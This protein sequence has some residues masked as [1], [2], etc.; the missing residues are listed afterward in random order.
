MHNGSMAKRDGEE[1]L[2]S[3]LNKATDPNN[4]DDRW[5]CIQEFYQ[6]VNQETDGPQVATRLLAHKI[7]SPQDN[8]AL[9]A[10][11]ILEACMDN[12][13]RRF[14]VE[15]VKFRFLNELI[16]VLIPKYLGK[17]SS[18]RVKERVT[19]VLYGW[20]LWLK[21]E[22]KI[23]EAYR[24]LKKQGIVK[25]DPTLSD[26]I[27]MPPP[28]QRT[29]ESVFDKEGKAE[30]LARLLKSTCPE[31]LQT[32]NRL[33][34]NTIKEEQEKAARESR[35]VSTLKEVETSVSK[36][37]E[38]LA[39]SSR[40]G[41]PVQHSE[42]LRV[43]YEHCDRLR[44]SLFRLASETTDDDAA[45][46]QLL[47]ANDELTQV[48]TTYKERAAKS[49]G[50]QAS[51]G[52]SWREE[53]TVYAPPSS[54]RGIRSYHLIDLSALDAPPD[55][56]TAESPLHPSPLSSSP[57]FLLSS[58]PPPA[59]SG[60]GTLPSG[61][62][63]ELI[64]LGITE[65]A[66]LCQTEGT[67]NTYSKELLLV[68]RGLRM[69][70]DDA[71]GGGDYFLPAQSGSRAKGSSG[72]GADTICSFIQNPPSAGSGL[73]LTLQCQPLD[74]PLSPGESEGRRPPP[75]PCTNTHLP[76]DA[77]RPSQLAP[78]PVWDQAGVHVSLHFPRDPP[79][80]NPGEAVVVLSAI[81]T[82]SLPVR[83]FL[84]KAAVPKGMSVKLQPSS[85]SQLPPFNP[86]LPPAAISQVLLLSNPQKLKVRLRYK[87]ALLHGDQPLSE[88][89]EI[90][91]FPPWTSLVDV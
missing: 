84:F 36:L 34:K 44:P 80:E 33:I 62:D 30:L 1:N 52:T 79:R 21:E 26:R 43:L 37:G 50:D 6:L 86:V 41:A 47:A 64:D 83:D 51:R 16:K 45:L 5:D 77:V 49:E 66:Q 73:A 82:S 3:W 8:E 28:S 18:D 40:T 42:E 4:M 61:V 27:A 31:D 87:L 12:C 74:G 71:C 89:G 46:A 35:R 91:S 76:M 20:T 81:N 7:Q 25:E 38:L 63:L 70:Y 58:L 19:E 60:N 9:Q 39:E 17:W 11:T 85:G 59:P 75:Q 65:H 54:P 15:A 69:N 14:Q 68:S 22:A 67:R 48:V 88:T 78:L 56:R 29:K 13:G 32:A 53:K 2:D 55:Q 72:K 90:E 24:M 23:Q 57:P 10:L